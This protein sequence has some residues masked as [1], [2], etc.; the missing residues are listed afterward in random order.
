[1]SAQVLRVAKNTS[2]FYQRRYAQFADDDNAKDQ[3]PRQRGLLK[4]DK[5]R[6]GGERNR[7]RGTGQSPKWRALFVANAARTFG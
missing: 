6:E 1:M 4:N 2:L 5:G 7:S 3:R